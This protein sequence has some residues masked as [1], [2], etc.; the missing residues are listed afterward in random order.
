MQHKRA[1]AIVKSMN[2]IA[3]PTVESNSRPGSGIDYELFLDCVHCGLCTS[4]CPTYLELGTEMD[5][6][7]GRIYLM[8][9]I[10]DGR[11]ALDGEV[12]KHLDLCLD[13][14]A[15]ETACPS[16]VKYGQLIEPF[17]VDLHK[18]DATHRPTTTSLPWWLRL[19]LFRVFPYKRR[20][21]L[22]LFPAKVMQSLGLDRLV[23]RSGLGRLLPGRTLEMLKM[24]PPLSRRF[25][26]L[27]QLL[28][29]E[30]TRRARVALFTGCVADVMF[31]DVNWMT[32]RVL[33][34]NG[35]EVVVPKTQV[36]CGAL[37][38]HAGQ[39]QPALA[40]ARKNIKVFL[41]HAGPLDAVIVNVAGCGSMLK[42]YDHLFGHSASTFADGEEIADWPQ[43]ASRFSHKVR[44]IHEF[45]MELGPVA[46]LGAVPLTAT[47]H[48]ACH[49]CHAQRIRTQPRDLLGMVPGLRLLPLA[50]S[51]VC[52]GAA[53]SYNLTQP[54]MAGRL[55]RRK[56]Q[57]ITE[58]GAEAV[59]TANAGCLMQIRRHLKEFGSKAGVLH[60]VEILWWSYEG[61]AQAQ[62]C[63]PVG[64]KK[65]SGVSPSG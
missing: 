59:L 52:C 42:E 30:G 37:H 47:Y 11:I 34:L 36:C 62:G 49:L 2:R 63:F 3:L 9:G 13:C 17:R 65:S 60:P 4:A 10:V 41:D 46:P 29:A 27:P 12:R 24:L 45:L 33:Q 48:D 32:A 18:L 38:F 6:P 23:E 20:A 58:T 21:R 5:S 1:F 51:E 26:R 25:G 28:P 31:S 16:G 57:K 40:F 53:G 15:C 19:L 14:R 7:R 8:R 55:G 56:A 54:E 61:H 43:R 35:C 22:A 50:E 39:D 64:L 44:D